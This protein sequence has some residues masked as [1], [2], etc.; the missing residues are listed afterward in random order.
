MKRVLVVFGT[1]PDAVKMAP[2]VRAFL[3]VPDRV[4][5]RVLVTAQH[6][7]MLDQV[8]SVFQIRPDYDLDV[9]Q[10]R[11]TLS[12]VTS[13]MLVELDKV[14]SRDKF[15]CVLVHG[16]TTT[17]FTAATAAFYQHLTVGHV[18]AGLRTPDLYTPFPEEMNRRVVD[19]LSQLHFA[20]TPSSRHNLLAEGHTD[21]TIFMTGN[22]AIDALR[23]M[24][25]LPCQFEG[26]LAD[27]RFDGRKVIAVTAHRRESWGEPMENICRAINTI[28]DRNPDAGVVF[29]VHLNPAVRDV[30]HKV[31]KA[32]P[33]RLLMLDPMDYLPWVNVMKQSW[34][35]LTDSGG[36]QEEAPALGK[37]VL[38]MRDTTEREDAVRYGTARL[39]GT[40]YDTIVGETERLLHDRSAYDAMARA[41]N[42]YGDGQACRR[43]VDATLFKLGVLPTRPAPFDP[44][45]APVL[46]GTAR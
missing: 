46:N 32:Y 38:V 12:D 28:L 16:D 35:I 34:I 30:V 7:Q 10:H 44:G 33:D 13:R 5:T 19:T 3:A 36:I 23:A 14:L 20:P 8:L 15:D 4:E 6:R 29:P 25:P 26:P 45:A 37:P 43:I 11:Q 22:T 9:M 40:D 1:R 21:D 31:I 42:P 2:L 18:E 41:V 17:A 24:E 39:V 27:Y